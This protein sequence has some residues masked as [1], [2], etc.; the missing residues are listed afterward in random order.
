[1]DNGLPP[2][3]FGDFGSPSGGGGPLVPRE[4]TRRQ[5]AAVIVRLLLA[6]GAQLPL[7]SLDEAT[8][9]SPN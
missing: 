6:E 4:L 9:E 5:K 1:M 7:D 3:R 2:V 8:Q